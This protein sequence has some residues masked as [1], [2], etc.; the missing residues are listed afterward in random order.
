MPD[1]ECR[2][3]DDDQLETMQWRTNTSILHIQR[4][5]GSVAKKPFPSAFQHNTYVPKAFPFRLKKGETLSP[6]KGEQ[7]NAE[8]SEK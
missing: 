1:P 8:T 2:I 7:K 4:I 3:L 5:F 6:S